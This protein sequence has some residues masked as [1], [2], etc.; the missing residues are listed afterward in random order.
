MAKRTAATKLTKTAVDD[1]LTLI[2]DA[3]QSTTPI[4]RWLGDSATQGLFARGRREGTGAARVEFCYRYRVGTKRRVM[5][6]GLYGELTVDQAQAKAADARQM[7]RVGLDPLAERTRRAAEQLAAE[8]RSASVAKVAEGYFADFERRVATGKKRGRR[9]TL[10]EWRRLLGKLSP[11]FL[12]LPVE[13]VEAAH[14]EAVHRAMAATPGNAN[15]T[16]TVLRAVFAF[17]ERRKLR[18]AGSNPARKAEVERF[19]EVGE[20]V[21]VTADELARLGVALREAEAK[22]AALP[23]G[24]RRPPKGV[25][26]P[27]AL[28]A[29]RLAALTGC[30]RSELVGHESTK[31]RG[32]GAGLRW[33]DVDLE[34]RVFRLRVAKAGRRDVPLGRA[35]VELLAR[36]RPPEARPTDAVCPSP[37]DPALPFVALTKVV[38]T[39]FAE[40]GIESTPQTRR[41]LHSLR[42]TF[43]T[44]ASSTGAGAGQVAQLLGHRVAK[45]TTDR[46]IHPDLDP[47]HL[48]ADRVAARIAA[49]LDGPPADVLPFPTSREVAS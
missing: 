17:A 49:I 47:L 24:C 36:V 2:R 5:Q 11:D 40:A 37:S 31:R 20:R 35:V 45:G 42:H 19:E 21:N 16:L 4:D 18:P 8:A 15:R 14:V 13:R 26:A 46:Y 29:V 28:L 23:E 25:H 38:R 10:A 7:V 30:R 32:D 33:G 9:S 22:A 1:L 43:G 12:R 6:L 48:A 34:A 41:D 44:L 27:G 39:L 3:P